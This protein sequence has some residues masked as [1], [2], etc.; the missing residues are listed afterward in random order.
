[1]DGDRLGLSVVGDQYSQM[2]EP[3]TA[4]PA[5]SVLEVTLHQGYKHT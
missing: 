1:M 3:K 2:W 4:P 5:G